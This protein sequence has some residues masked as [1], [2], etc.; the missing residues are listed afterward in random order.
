[1]RYAAALA[2]T[3]PPP[4]SVC[5]FT[6]S[7]SEA[8]DLALRLARAHTRGACARNGDD[9]NERLSP[10]ELVG[11]VFIRTHKDDRNVLLA[12]VTARACDYARDC[13][14]V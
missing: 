6:C 4:L 9:V 10:H 11:V 13:A 1:V 7:G 3:F 2:A 5:F 8:N 14:R 12:R